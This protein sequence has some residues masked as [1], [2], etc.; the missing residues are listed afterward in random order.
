MNPRI[1]LILGDPC[2]IGPEVAARLLALPGVTAAAD[3]VILGE[4]HVLAAG[5]RVAGVTVPT[6]PAASVGEAKPAPGMP[7][8]VP[9]GF[10][11]A[12]SITPGTASAACGRAMLQ[13][14]RFA[15][16]AAR[17]G[18]LDGVL[19][20][21]LNKQAMKAGG[22]EHE[23]ELRMLQDHLQDSGYVS[24]FNITGALWTSRVTSH[25]PISEVAGALTRAGVRDA[26][27]IIHDSQ[28]MAGVE[29]PRIAVNGLNPHAGDGGTIGREEIDIIGPAIADMQSAGIDARGPFSPD[30][31]F[32]AARRG[33]FDAVV[34]MYH[35]QG[36][37]AMKLMG[38]E[39]GVTLLGGLPVPITTPAHG[40]AFDIAGRGVA[41]V[42]AIRQAF[43][44]V[45]RMAAAR[46]AA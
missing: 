13:Y 41:R 40:T 35:D 23:D 16:D 29:R 5:V 45:R 42:D 2:G 25:I 33:D 26:I 15:A 10:L 36:Q 30:T 8:I 21:P 19:F 1:G 7:A 44:I 43:D 18:Q 24:E 3:I 12:A 17:A 37:I 27:R 9:L 46:R 28:R 20:A 38:F 31:V 4:P 6:R 39:T 14:L 11:D 34:T 22:L 32:I